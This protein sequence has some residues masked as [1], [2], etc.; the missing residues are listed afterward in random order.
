MVSLLGNPE[1]LRIAVVVVKVVAVLV[2]AQVV[3]LGLVEVATG[4]LALVLAL[5]PSG[6][7]ESGQEASEPDV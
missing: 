7:T 3:A 6:H 2:V 5:T 1:V 4:L